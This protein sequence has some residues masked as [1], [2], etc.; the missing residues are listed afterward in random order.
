MGNSNSF[1]FEIITVYHYL[2]CIAFASFQYMQNFTGT[3]NRHDRTVS[4]VVKW[5][6]KSHHEYH[7]DTVRL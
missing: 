6:S 7:S 3:G 1:I 5:S 2:H 4:V